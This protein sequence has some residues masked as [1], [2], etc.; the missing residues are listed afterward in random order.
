MKRV[1]FLF[2]FMLLAV[3]NRVQAHTVTMVGDYSIIAAWENEPPV[4]GEWNAI[5]IDIFNVNGEIE[6]TDLALR[7]F[8]LTNAETTL[9][10]AV[11][12]IMKETVHMRVAFMP[13]ALGEIGVHIV[14]TLG[15]E[16]LDVTVYP[17]L[18]EPVSIIQFPDVTLSNAQLQDGLI[19]LEDQ[20]ASQRTQLFFAYL[21]GGLG[22]LVGVA[23]FISA[24]RKQ[25]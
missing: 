3:G 18:V 2:L 9:A 24:R 4:I 14:G 17:E 23:G 15:G 20:L 21:I 5:T 11:S 10:A 12:P 16:P 1:I 13:T 25:V 19:L 7:Q 22:V 6:M 8:E